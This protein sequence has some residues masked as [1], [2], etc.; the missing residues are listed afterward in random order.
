MLGNFLMLPVSGA[1]SLPSRLVAAGLTST[2]SLRSFGCCYATEC[3]PD[4]H[5]SGSPHKR[6]RVRDVQGELADVRPLNLQRGHDILRSRTL[7]DAQFSAI[8]RANLMSDGSSGLPSKDGD[9]D[10]HRVGQLLVFG[11]FRAMVA[12]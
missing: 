12:M 9:R 11:I 8:T 2:R 7:R 4:V 3:P 5:G 1:G 10:R 6:R